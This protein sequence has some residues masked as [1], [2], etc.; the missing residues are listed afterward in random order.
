MTYQAPVDDIMH[1]LKAAAG[2]DELIRSGVLEGIDEET[3]RAVIEEAGKFG[4][5][6]LDPLSA[7]GDRAG[8]KLVDGKVVTPDGWKAAYKQ[9]AEGG[10]GALAASEEWGGQNLPQVVATA[11]GEIWNAA[12]L[13][14]GLCPLLT[15]GAIDAIEAQ[16]SEDLKKTYLPKMVTGEWTGTMNLTEPHAGSDLGHLKTRAEKQAD[17]TYRIFGTKIFI[18]YGDH[19]MTDNIIHLVLARLPDAPPGTRGISL[20]LVPKY[21]VNEDGSLGE[22]NDVVCAGLEHKLGIHASPTA[23]M[24]YGEK[25]GAVGYLV[26]E[27]NRGLNVMFIMMNAAR[28]AVGTQGVSVAERATQQATA[29]ARERRQGRTASSRGGEMGPII[30]HAD[31][32][33]TLMTMK[34]LTQAARAICL[35][36]ARETDVARRAKDAGR[37]AAAANRVALLTPVAKAFSTD[38]GCEVASMGVQVHGGMGFIEET[39]AA[40]IYRDARILPI[41]EGTNGIQA[42]DLVTRKLPL[43]GGNVVTQYIGELLRTVEE[44]RASNRPEFGRMAERLGE[45]VSALA[46]ASRW[47]GTSLQNNPDAALAGATP[48]L[49]LFGLASGGVYLARGALAAARSGGQAAP[50]AVAR[51]FAENIASAAP[52]LKE[53]VT[54]GAESTLM[55]A[56]EALSA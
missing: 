3:I 21:L 34:A 22:R 7:A 13:A 23:V 38:I 5:E 50:I 45:A 12:N 56:P 30:E 2:L 9:F 33:R 19:E 25:D 37:R 4:S 41:Y 26:G 14:F 1:A 18:T 44:V 52:G 10:W 40:Q 55:L 51:F 31:I 39:G 20:F 15:F 27:E 54:G 35:V 17:G 28:L 6:V 47:M 36:T 29:Y 8:S 42:L 43:E 48:Y 16:G 32:R 24:K 11:A 53:T 46:D 49:R